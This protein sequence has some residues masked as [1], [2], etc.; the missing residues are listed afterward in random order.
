MD[1]VSFRKLTEEEEQGKKCPR[2]GHPAH[3]EAKIRGRVRSH[4]EYWC[5]RCRWKLIRQGCGD[6]PEVEVKIFGSGC[7][8]DG[9][10]GGWSSG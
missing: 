4:T 5:S 8:T 9:R 1:I 10:S 3:Y 7:T 2:C 6:A